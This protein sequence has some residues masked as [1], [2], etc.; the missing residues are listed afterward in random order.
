[1]RRPRVV[2]VI[3]SPTELDLAIRIAEPPDLFELRLDRLVRPSSQG[4]GAARVIN[5]LETK[6][7][8]LRAPFVITA[9]HPMEGGA[10]R[11]SAVAATRS[12][13]SIL[14][15][16][17]LYR[18]RIAVSARFR[19]AASAGSKAKRAPNHFS[20]SPEKHPVSQSVTELKRTRQKRMVRTFF[21]VATRT[22]TPAQ[23]TR[24][25]DF[26]RASD[27]DIPVSAMGIGRARRSFA[28]ASRL[29]WI[30]PCIRFTRPK[31]HR[32]ADVA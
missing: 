26:R 29:F 12:P 23:L 5:R 27:V 13:L 7:S 4:Q 18:C 31:R 2:G 1:M 22:D 19:F 25:I 8:K 16:G 20:S 17:P 9:R 3:S 30:D 32:G 6:I 14:V 10:N 24:L 15:P 21:K 11:L 28:S